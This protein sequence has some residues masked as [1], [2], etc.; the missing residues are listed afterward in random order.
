MTYNPETCKEKSRHSIPTCDP[1]ILVT[2]TGLKEVNSNS[3]KRS[4]LHTVPFTVKTGKLPGMQ[5]LSRQ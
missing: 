3:K 1:T 4:N 5:E 2:G